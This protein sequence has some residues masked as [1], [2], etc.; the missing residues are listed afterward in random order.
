[1]KTSLGKPQSDAWDNA[2]GMADELLAGG[3]WLEEM[4]DATHFHRHDLKPV[5]RL[6]L[7]PVGRFGNHVFYNSPGENRRPLSRQA[8][9]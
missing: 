6:S 3:A 7:V 2:R 5:W 4:L 8:G 9:R 1:M